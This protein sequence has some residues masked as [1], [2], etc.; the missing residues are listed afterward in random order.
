MLDR[1]GLERFGSE[2]RSVLGDFHTVAELSKG[3]PL[4]ATYTRNGDQPGLMVERW[5]GH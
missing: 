1:R 5:K 3:Y 4:L 2:V